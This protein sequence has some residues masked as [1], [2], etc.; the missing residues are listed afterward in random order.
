MKE[1][2]QKF[3]DWYERN[4]VL[5][6]T[7]ALVLFVLQVIHLG[8]LGGEV[9]AER[10][11][12]LPLFSFDGIWQTIIILVD[13][14]EIPAIFTMSLVYVDAW[15]RGAKWNAVL[16]LAL[17]HSQWLHIFWITDEFVVNTFTGEGQHTH[18]TVL[19]DWLAWVA[20]L[21]DYLEVPVIVDTAWK[22]W[23]ATTKER[24]LAAVKEAL[25]E[26]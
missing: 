3:W 19:P 5:N 26:E 8:W 17:L 22:L 16:M 14:T 20:I 12:G 10:L 13:Y 15:R 2:W 18:S 4:Y 23:R 1:I 24:S 11:T 21:I 6:V 7:I 9:I 25:D